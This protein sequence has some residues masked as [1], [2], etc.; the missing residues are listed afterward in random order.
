MI[1]LLG[2]QFGGHDH[3]HGRQPSCSG[4][5]RSR[6]H[7]QWQQVVEVETRPVAT[8]QVRTV[9]NEEC[10]CLVC[11]TQYEDPPSEDWIQCSMCGDWAHEDCTAYDGGFYVYATCAEHFES[12]R[13][14]LLKVLNIVVVILLFAFLVNLVHHRL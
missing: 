8:D 5:W 4:S 7:S 3:G 1:C 13:L 14:G 12:S 2:R 10:F 6:Q 9:E 11:G